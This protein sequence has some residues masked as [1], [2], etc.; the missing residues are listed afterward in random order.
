MNI[1][2]QLLIAS[3]GFLATAPAIADA[4]LRLEQIFGP[5]A[6][7]ADRLP[8]L[9]WSGINGY[10]R[11][12]PSKEIAGAVDLARYDAASGSRS[13]AV[14]ARALTPRGATQPLVPTDH[15]WSADRRRILLSIATAGAAR[16]DP[17]VDV[18]VYEVATKQLRRL[19]GE[20]AGRLLYPEF[21]PDG[22]R[23]AFV[24]ANNLLVQTFDDAAPLQLTTDGSEL[25]LNGR[26]D[27]VHEEE[28]AL[29]KAYSWS[30]DSR[31]LAYWQFDTDGVA[32]FTMIRNTDGQYSRTVPLRYPKPG[33]TNSA[34]RVGVVSADRPG[35]TWFALEGDARNHYVPRMD[36][37]ADGAEVLLQ[38]ENRPQNT[39]Q[40]FLGNAGT[41]E[42][43][44]LFTETDATWLLPSDSVRWLEGGRS[45]TWMSERDGWNH[46]Y[47]MA[48]D[49]G[50][51]QLRTPGAFDVISI[52]A[53]DTGYAYFI[54]S[55]DNVAQRYLYRATLSGSP[56]VERLTPAGYTG[57]HGY[58]LAPG[59][60]WAIHT[61]S[62]A[63]APP[64]IS[65]IHLPSHTRGRV[66]TD[67]AA[68]RKLLGNT[69]RLA[70]EFL[71]LD[72][73]EVV[74]DAWLL[75]PPDFD[76]SKKYPLLMYVY[77]EP[78]GQTVV[79]RWGG[80]R[81]LW[82]L[83]LAQRGYVV[84]S[85]DSRGAAAPRGHDWRRSV[86]GQIGILASAD[87]AA[88]V[89]KL[90]AGRP[91]LDPG[92]VGVWGWSG[93]GAMTLNALFRYPGLYS[94]GI[95]VASPVDQLLY[96]SIYQER[97]MG[98]PADNAAG[99]RD[100]SPV[101]FAQNLEGHL[102]IIHGTGD[103]NVH[104]QN[105]EQLV[106]RLVSLNKPFSLMAYPDRTH[107]I[108]EGANTR[109]HL[110]S[111][112]TRFLDEHLLPARRDVKR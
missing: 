14:P 63:D 4:G 48:R 107:G 76:A 18:W 100:G 98:L 19:G 60:K 71:Q 9:R 109:L 83:M 42:L 94:T 25:M 86:Y 37:T 80:D 103:D 95:A 20:W 84:A 32:V 58:D 112:A 110:F 38:Y 30:P 22:K 105:A 56:R 91:Y 62:R 78:A 21:S 49:T 6:V 73:G 29:A 97:Y 41:G 90:L 1:T 55:P 8:A 59:A 34:M 65:V 54:A 88:A 66:L 108:S 2:S 39:N 57:T 72:I 67:N 23:V 64:S 36:W 89:R 82:H 13:I 3:L 69:P 92:R 7:Q 93:G 106:N 43:R 40:V 85:V 28:F 50:R 12:E 81:Y 77:S 53:I 17:L 87:Q 75:K 74:L 104:Y 102:L 15:Q 70:T 33:T 11:L 27:L 10:T 99:Y 26:G 61:H 68:L 46:L 5:A 101:N 111:L 52:E 45:F 96:N 31:R 35:T 51:A 24:A 44:L 16:N 79:D 47:V